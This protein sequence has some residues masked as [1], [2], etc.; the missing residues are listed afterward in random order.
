M[1]LF[2]QVLFNK[3]T[4]MYFFE[5]YFQTIVKYDLINKFKY[6]NI[7]KLPKLRKIVLNF[8]C[9]NSDTKQLAL[10]MTALELITLQKGILTVTKKSNVI[11]KLKKGEPIG[12]KVVLRKTNMYNF[13]FKILNEILPKINKFK[14]FNIKQ[15]RNN[16]SKINT[17]SFKLKNTLNFLELEK[18]YYIYQ[19]LP[20]LNVTFVTNRISFCEFI[21]LFQSFKMSSHI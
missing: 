11:L 20:F 3:N 15:N 13:L 8:S 9:K 6:K 10:T 1:L 7:K 17:F 14:K 2:Q 21:F 12:C 4:K 18:N 16:N 19:N 5:H